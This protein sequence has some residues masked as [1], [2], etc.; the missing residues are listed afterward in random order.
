MIVVKEFPKKEFQSKEDLFEALVENKRELI[1]IKKS[2]IKFCEPIETFVKED[3][4]SK[5]L[6][7]AYKDDIGLGVI[8]RQIIGNTYYWGDQHNDVHL[9]STFKKSIRERGVAKIRFYHDH[10]NQ[11]GAKVGK[12]SNVKEKTVTWKDLGVEIEGETQILVA[13]AEIIKA[14]NESVFTQYLNNEIDQHSVGMIYGDIK[15]AINDKKYEEEYKEFHLHIDKIGN[16]DKVMKSGFYWAV[17]DAKLIEISAVPEG[18]NSMTFTLPNNKQEPSDDILDKNEPS[19]DTQEEET[20]KTEDAPK[21][22]IYH[23]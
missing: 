20:Q 13:D 18:S 3:S 16:K 23:N 9:K 2:V 11:V 5:E 7:T 21:K 17:Y 15:M 19:G 1:D 22:F 10:I 6:G 14:Y 12:F 8:K 4:A